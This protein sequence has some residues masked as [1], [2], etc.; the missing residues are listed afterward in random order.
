[1]SNAKAFAALDAQ[2]AMVEGLGDLAASAA[3]DVADVVEKAFQRQIRAGTD[4]EGVAW[5][6]TQEGKQP[7]ETAGKALAVAPIGTRILC[8][9]KGH[10]ARH[11]RGTAKGGIVRAVFPERGIPGPMVTKIKAVLVDEFKLRVGG[12]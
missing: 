3:P 8:V 10:I 7:L 9:L 1:V 2:I 4:A 11:H 5:Q 12:E 6:K